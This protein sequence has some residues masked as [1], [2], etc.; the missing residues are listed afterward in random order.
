[1]YNTHNLIHH[2]DT[3]VGISRGDNSTRKLETPELMSK[4]KVGKSRGDDFTTKLET[5]EQIA[6]YKVGNSRGDDVTTKLE[7]PEVLMKPQRCKLQR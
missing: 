4:Y 5:S 1:M 2:Q 3:I 7:T 6:K